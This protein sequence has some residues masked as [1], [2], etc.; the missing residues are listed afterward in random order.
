[1]K[2]EDILDAIRA[3]FPAHPL[4]TELTSSEGW[5]NPRRIDAL[6]FNPGYRRTAIEVKVSRADAKR[7]TELKV[8]P[9]R[10]CTNRFVY[11]V[12][13]G[14]LDAPPIPGCGLWWVED[15]AT[16]TVK[17]RATVNHEPE[18]LPA[19]VVSRIAF[20]AHLAQ[21]ADSVAHM[22]SLEH[23]ISRMDRT[24]QAERKANR[25]ELRIHGVN[26]SALRALWRHVR[27]EGEDPMELVPMYCRDVLTQ[28]VDLWL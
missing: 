26:E 16:I 2:A 10:A 1:M 13:A 3:K 4:I 23:Q 22:R 8:A 24:I 14:L 27:D 21:Q 12:P 25:Q 6:Q 7:E 18:P 17:A 15:D 11:A 19:D 9:W 5:R 20:R 28:E